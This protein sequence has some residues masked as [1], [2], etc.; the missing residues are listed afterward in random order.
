MIHMSGTQRNE[1]R[2]SINC[3]HDSDR[4]YDLFDTAY[5]GERLFANDNKTEDRLGLG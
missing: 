4:I 3:L 5:Q 1:K 2:P